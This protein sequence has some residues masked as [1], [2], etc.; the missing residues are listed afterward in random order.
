[1]KL[2]KFAVLLAVLALVLSS[3]ACLS[4]SSPAGVSNLY[5]STDKE[6]T[7]KTT[8]FTPTDTIY[9]SFDVNQVD[10]GASFDIKW[11]ALNVDG[12]DP[13]TPFITSNYIYGSESSLSAHINSTTGGFPVAQY[14]VEIFINGTKAAE[15]QFDIQ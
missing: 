11:Y 14:K 4:S 1:M 10:K 9:V 7:N 15:Q 5:M 3:L 6:G 2:N 8:T 13:N 12:Q